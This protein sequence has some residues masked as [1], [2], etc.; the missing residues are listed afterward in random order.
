MR[1]SLYLL[2]GL[3]LSLWCFGIGLA[4]P[5]PTLPPTLTHVIQA[6]RLTEE[7]AKKKYPLHFRVVVTYSTSTDLFV[8]DST[9]GIWVGRPSSMAQPRTGQLLD[10]EGVTTQ[11]DFAPDVAEPHW[12]ILGEAPMPAPKHATYDEMASTS[13]DSA[14]VEFEGTVRSAVE[15][16]P[17]PNNTRRLRLNLVVDGNRLVVEI[18]DYV[19]QPEQW[20]GAVVRVQGV[21]AALFNDNNQLIGL[22]IHTP[23][24]RYIKVVRP[25]LAEDFAIPVSP[26]SGIQRFTFSGTPSRRVR[27]QGVVTASIA[28][29]AF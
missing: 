20:V 8:Q 11:T 25:A 23:N 5:A 15:L 12:R 28:N 24:P 6:R 18:Q 21:C 17:D 19:S 3:N 27:V 10:L 9:G 4:Q 29:K 2:V 1:S 16:P 26:I 7:Q 22:I 13:D 14:W